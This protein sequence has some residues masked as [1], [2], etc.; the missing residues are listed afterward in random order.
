MRG[1]L[2]ELYPRARAASVTRGSLRGCVLGSGSGQ[3]RV[4]GLLPLARLSGHT[5]HPG[6]TEL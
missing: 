6:D 2:G 4:E 3:A 5:E 1:Q